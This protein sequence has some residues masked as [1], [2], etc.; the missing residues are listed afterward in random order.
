MHLKVSTTKCR[1]D[2]LRHDLISARMLAL[3]R[4]TGIEPATLCLEVIDTKI[5][6]QDLF[7]YLSDTTSA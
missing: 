6:F 2:S 7:S 5:G 1:R 3:E 4:E